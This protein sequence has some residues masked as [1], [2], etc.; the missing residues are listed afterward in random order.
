MSYFKNIAAIVTLGSTMLVGGCSTTPEPSSTIE[1]TLPG[2]KYQL[3]A[4]SRSDTVHFKLHTN[5][6]SENQRRAL[7]QIADKA[8][9]ASG[10]AI[11]LVITTSNHPDS[12]RGGTAIADYL[13][14]RRVYASSISLATAENLP[15]DVIAVSEIEYRTVRETCNRKWDNLTKTASNKVQS[16]FG[17]AVTA[18]MAAQIADPRDVAA[19]Q[20][21]TPAD[22]GRK[23]T[24]IDKYRKGEITSSA[25][26]EAARGTISDAIK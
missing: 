10:T 4:E 9:W 7:D 8:S 12:I 23:V 3:A 11:D 18:N 21:A 22:A 16:N 20:P 17:C 25:E 6:F 15:V 1:A 14:A 26:N 13:V 2:G 19:P 5:G 24:I